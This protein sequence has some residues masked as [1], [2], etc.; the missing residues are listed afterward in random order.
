VRHLGTFDGMFL[1]NDVV[2][3]EGLRELSRRQ[4]RSCWTGD[5]A[6]ELFA[7]YSFMT[8]TTPEDIERTVRGFA[9]TMHFNGPALGRSLGIDVHSP[10]LHPDVM[11][12]AVSLPGTAMVQE[13]GGPR[14][15]AEAAEVLARDGVRLRSAEHLAYYRIYRDV[16]GRS[17]RGSGDGAMECPACGARR[18]EGTYCRVCGDYPV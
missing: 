7:G 13:H 11:A 8:S 12:H 16:F 15:E 10:F 5:G 4:M 6:D 9:Q 14:Y 18:P 2:V 17:P 3:W 1:R